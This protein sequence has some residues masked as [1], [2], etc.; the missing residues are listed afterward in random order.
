M[1][2]IN[3]VLE[4]YNTKEKN[5]FACFPNI[6]KLNSLVQSGITISKDELLAYM[7][8]TE[9][10]DRDGFRTYG[11]LCS[12]ITHRLGD[13]DDILS[14]NNESVQ[15]I[16]I[17]NDLMQT[18]ITER[19]G[20][21][22]GLCVVNKIHG[23]T[24]ADWKK[25]STVPGRSGHPTFDFEILIASTGTN[26]IQAENKGSAIADNSLKIGSVQ[27]HYNNIQGKKD[28]VRK[29]EAKRNIPMHQNYYY[30]T[31]GVLDN[32]EN[33]RAKVWLIDPPA[34]EIKMKP[35]KYKLLARLR[36][37][38][39]EFKNI[40]VKSKITYALE[41]RI[42][43]IEESS[44]YLSFDNKAL[45]YKYP[46]AFHLFMDGKMFAAVDNNE[47]FGRIFIVEHKQNNFPYLIA[48]P[49]ALM[50]IIILQNF[51]SILE[52]EYNPDFISEDVQVLM[53]IGLKDFES[54]KLPSNMKFI[55]NERRKY[56]E[57]TYWGKV[58]HTNDGRIFGLLEKGK[59]IKND[60]QNK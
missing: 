39:D 56:F 55:L 28:Y 23:L 4:Y 29:E 33:S 8:F 49:K 5:L 11:E 50:R 41:K 22:L 59:N 17:G 30:G 26:F 1:S 13:I 24:A 20:V 16:I 25:I 14:F 46:T 35:E 2:L 31:I 44:D 40:G 10:M 42:K 53:R 52:Y 58:S 19:L 43:E 45:D 48:F 32:N 60:Y 38:L 34:F 54:S 36:F 21:A 51:N 7:M 18:G 12:R 6:V 9:Q 37:Y 57:A 3:I 27:A 47:A 15:A